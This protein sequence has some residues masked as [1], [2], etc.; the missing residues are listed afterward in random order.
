MFL[1][2]QQFR[3]DAAAF[4]YSKITYS[5]SNA[6]GMLYDFLPKIG[7]FNA[8][9]L[10]SLALAVPEALKSSP[11]RSFNVTLNLFCDYLTGLDRL[12]LMTS[13]D[14]LEMAQGEEDMS[15]YKKQKRAVLYTAA[16]I[17]QHHTKLRTAIWLAKSG[18]CPKPGCWTQYTF[19]VRIVA[20]DVKHIIGTASCFLMEDEID[21]RPPLKFLERQVSNVFEPGYGFH[22]TLPR[23]TC[24]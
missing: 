1:V 13:F 7:A 21:H 8:A 18:H 23:R 4:L 6:P 19:Y 11:G 20:S 24:F 3:T 12:E 22:L 10:K 14:I 15:Q 17:T 16:N 5:S 2:C 9:S